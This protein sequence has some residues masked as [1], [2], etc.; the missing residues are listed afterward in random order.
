MSAELLISSARLPE[1]FKTHIV[2]VA[3]KAE[4]HRN[5]YT[6]IP[7]S[8][9]FADLGLSESEAIIAIDAAN[10]TSGIHHNSAQHLRPFEY[11][12][13]GTFKLE[14][15]LTQDDFYRPF[16]EP[17]RGRFS[18]GSFGVFYSSLTGTTCLL[19]TGYWFLK[20]ASHEFDS[21][22]SITSLVEHRKLIWANIDI[23]TELNLIAW[24]DK[25]KVIAEKLADPIDH[26]FCQEV[27]MEARNL[28][29]TAIRSRSVRHE[30]GTNISV[31]DPKAIAESK[32]IAFY[33]FHANRKEP[34]KL[35]LEPIDCG[36]EFV[37]LSSGRLETS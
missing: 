6:V 14:I 1:S 7:S 22:T 30:G 23:K 37:L 15:G 9:L 5:I 11:A 2:D 36:Q 16:K 32:G 24:S 4:V 28:G 12:D 10:K 18:N 33:K 13:L 8:N 29:I 34:E 25:S 19:E 31:L 35:R 17:I 27:G 21:D 20:K 3:N 26:G